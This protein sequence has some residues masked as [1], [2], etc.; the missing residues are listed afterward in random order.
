MREDLGCILFVSTCVVGKNPN[1]QNL[2]PMADNIFARSGIGGM[3]SPLF[4]Y[5]WHAT[6]K[7]YS[8]DRLQLWHMWGVHWGGCGRPFLVKTKWCILSSPGNGANTMRLSGISNC[9]GFCILAAL[10]SISNGF[11]TFSS[12]AGGGSSWGGAGGGGGGGM[13][14]IG[15][16]SGICGECTEVDVDGPS[17]SFWASLQE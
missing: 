11:T 7:R 2:S 12:C 10:I 14:S 9:F 15:C 13:T 8:R 5:G 6:F 1:T 17:S 4:I 3:G 16:S